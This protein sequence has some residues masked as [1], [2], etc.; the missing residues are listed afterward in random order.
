MLTYLYIYL[1]CIVSPLLGLAEPIALLAGL[2]QLYWPLVVVAVTAG[3]MT[4]FLLCI[5]SAVSSEQE[6]RGQTR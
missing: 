2:S 1:V 6:S 5:N 4:C 3:Q